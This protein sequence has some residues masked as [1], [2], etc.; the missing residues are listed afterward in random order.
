MLAVGAFDGEKLIGLAGM[1][2]GLQRYVADRRRRFAGIPAE[3]GRLCRYR[4][5]RIG[6]LREGQAALLL[7]RMV[8]YPLGTQCA[9]LRVFPRMGGA[10]GE[11][12]V[13]RPGNARGKAVILYPGRGVSRVLSDFPAIFFVP[14]IFIR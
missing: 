7:R 14:F 12:R 1:L 10:D 2:G 5:A 11:K 9:A 3:R 6:N 8:E 4:T 13:L